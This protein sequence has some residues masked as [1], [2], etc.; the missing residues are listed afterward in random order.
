MWKRRIL[1]YLALLAAVALIVIFVMPSFRSGRPSIAG[2]TA[3]NFSFTLDGHHTQLSALRGKIVILNFWATWCPPCVEETPSLEMMSQEVKPLGMTVLGVS[4]DE[5]A[6]A[7]STFLVNHHVTFP[8]Y[9]DP[10]K[11]IP[12]AYGT[13][14]YPESYIIGRNG[15]ILRKLIGAQNWTSPHMLDYLKAIAKGQ[16]PKVF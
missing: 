8:T 12:V 2:R 7:Y 4:V 6:S 11:K 16:R 10:S 9:R 14:M 15:V 3:P 13:F 1:S 5:D